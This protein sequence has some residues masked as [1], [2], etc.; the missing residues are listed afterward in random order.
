MRFG[1]TWFPMIVGSNERR[2]AFM[3]EGF[4]TFIDTFESDE[5]EGGVYGPKRDAEYAPQGG[6][7][8]DD[9]LPVL[10][11]PEAP[12]IMTRADLIDERYRHPVTYFKAALGL[13][14]LRDDILGPDRFDPAFRKYIADWAFR[15][16]KPAD[17][18]RTLDS[19]AGEDLSWWW[20]GWFMNN[21]TLDLAVTDVAYVD[22][23]PAKGAKVTVE[24][25]G[26]LVMP[27]TMEVR[28]I[29]GSTRRVALPVETWMLGASDVVNVAG[30][31]AIASVTIDPD[32][33]LPDRDRSN[34]LFRMTNGAITPVS[35]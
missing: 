21:W 8:V 3:D 31:A 4:N 9:I 34:N 35:K 24:S 14:L 17:F 30:G 1:H 19:E 10:A 18:F 13:R 33:R 5:F 23:D 20:R 11:D 2:N 26:R 22:G 12:P 15:H 28:Y 16:P 6:N 25:L 32:H 27:A 29:N 7:P